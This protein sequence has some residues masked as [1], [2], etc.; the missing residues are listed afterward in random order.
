MRSVRFLITERCNASCPSCINKDIR[1]ESFID[2]NKFEQLCAFFKENTVS[3]IKIMGGEPTLHPFFAEI[4]SIAQN[5]FE[6]VIVFSNGTCD[7]LR[8]FKPRCKDSINLNFLFSSRWSESFLCHH[9]NCAHVFEIMVNSK[10]NVDL[11]KK[12]ITRIWNIKPSDCCFSLTLDCTA[13]IFRDRTILTEKLLKIYDYCKNLKSEV[14]FDHSLPLCFVYGTRIPIRQKG[15]FCDTTCAC[16]VDANCNLFYCN[17]YPGKKL[18]IFS[19]GGIIPF[20]IIENHLKQQYYKN[21]MIALEKIC[22]SCPL[23]E[24]NC[25]GGCYISSPNIAKEDILSNTQMP[26]KSLK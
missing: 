10:T 15:A 4:T 11:V 3:H 8:S 19:N 13:N 26:L 23:Y 6:R 5:Y 22:C 14:I 18:L 24:K 2:L 9:K 20:E 12:E 7:S 17:Q 1:G 16:S 21:Q 25:N